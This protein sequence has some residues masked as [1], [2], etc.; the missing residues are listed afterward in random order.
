MRS[1][2]ERDR[3]VPPYLPKSLV[4][5]LRI[6]RDTLRSVYFLHQYQGNGMADLEVTLQLLDVREFADWLRT[7]GDPTQARFAVDIHEALDAAEDYEEVAGA[8]DG[9][10]DSPTLHLAEKAEQVVREVQAIDQALGDTGG[11][12]RMAHVNAIADAAKLG[13]RMRAV[14]VETGALANDDSE[15]DPAALLRALLS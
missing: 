12:P 4:A 7:H 3:E 5:R 11:A 9:W 10:N 2:I 13:E 1:I 6:F 14:L 8:L 15:T